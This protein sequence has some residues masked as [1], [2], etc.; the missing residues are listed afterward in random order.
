M[1]KN[2]QIIINDTTSRCDDS[3]TPTTPSSPT[4][5][6]FY[7]ELC[8]LR[9]VDN[10]QKER[11]QELNNECALLVREIERL[12]QVPANKRLFQFKKNFYIKN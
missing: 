6:S 11:I 9:I 1:T 2:E 5:Q 10:R 8:M 4:T 7:D 12:K 3:T